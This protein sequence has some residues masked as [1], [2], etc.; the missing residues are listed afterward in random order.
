MATRRKGGAKGEQQPPAA[1]T[2]LK[3]AAAPSSRGSLLTLLIKLIRFAGVWSWIIVYYPILAF[4]YTSL[5][6]IDL[7]DEA[8]SIPYS[9][10]IIPRISPDNRFVA[11]ACVCCYDLLT[12]SLLRSRPLLR[13][14]NPILRSWGYANGNMPSDF[15][16]TK[17]AAVIVWLSGINVVRR[18][19]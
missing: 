13:F 16:Q 11:V 19:T 9:L 12:R 7:S 1:A 10:L 3:P 17:W 14:L 2:T 4:G 5:L 15:I 18:L 6:Q 8:C